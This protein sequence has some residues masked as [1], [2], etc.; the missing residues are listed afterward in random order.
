[1]KKLGAWFNDRV[2]GALNRWVELAL[3]ALAIAFVGVLA[4]HFRD[5]F[6]FSVMVW[7]ACVVLVA[8]IVTIGLVSIYLTKRPKP[9]TLPQPEQ[10]SQPC[11]LSLLDFYHVRDIRD[12]T[13]FKLK[14][15]VVFRNDFSAPLE[16]TKLTWLANS[17][18]ILIQPPLAYFFQVESQI[19]TWTNQDTWGKE[20]GEIVVRPGWAFRFWI[21]VNEK[22]Q[23]AYIRQRREA[24]KIGTATLTVKEGDQTREL[25]IRL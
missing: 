20:Y 18:E 1:M 9:K 4:A 11:P 14:L 10:Q 16:I 23:D 24:R 25:P 19:G 3:I 6:Y 5:A 13:T 15:R 21:G 17:D 22:Y 8:T 12:T 7:Q 2:K